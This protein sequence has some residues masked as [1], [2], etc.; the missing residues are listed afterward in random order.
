MDF[1]ASCFFLPVKC[2]CTARTRTTP[3]LFLG[4]KGLSMREMSLLDSPSRDTIALEQPCPTHELRCHKVI[5]VSLTSDFLCISPP[6]T[7][8]GTCAFQRV[9]FI[10]LSPEA[11]AS[12]R[13]TW[14]TFVMFSQYHFYAAFTSQSSRNAYNKQVFVT[15]YN[16]GGGRGSGPRLDS[17]PFCTLSR[18]PLPM[19]GSRSEAI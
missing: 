4:T 15:P 10:L 12:G 7:H 3:P 11:Y 16:S 8:S 2:F 5:E 14:M 19:S 18:V 9:F 1:C 13:L 17:D 6:T